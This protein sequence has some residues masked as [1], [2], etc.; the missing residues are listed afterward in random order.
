MMTVL[1]FDLIHARA[2]ITL[3]KQRIQALPYLT[4]LFVTGCHLSYVLCIEL[5]K[6]FVEWLMTTAAPLLSILLSA[7]STSPG[8]VIAPLEHTSTLC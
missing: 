8:I 4:L 5:S 6:L 2:W 7:S 1:R 3:P